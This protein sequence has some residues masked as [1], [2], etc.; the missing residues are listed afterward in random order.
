MSHLSANPND[1]EIRT[2]GSGQEYVETCKD[3]V[4]A[5]LVTFDDSPH[6]R[7]QEH[8]EAGGNRLHLGPLVPLGE[9]FAFKQSVD[10]LVGPYIRE[11]QPRLTK[12]PLSEKSV[13]D[14]FYEV[15][16][17]VRVVHV[18]ADDTDYR[19]EIYRHYTNPQ[20]P[21]VVSYFVEHRVPHPNMQA[22][23]EELDA[24]FLDNSLPWVAE[25]TCESALAT[26]LGFLAD[27]HPKKRKREV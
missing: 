9:W 7:I 15:K 6:I 21:Y 20:T 2:D 27:R 4:R 18:Q 10:K 26:A 1:S 25:R 17:L 11:S 8:H 12:D 13:R 24:Y 14:K 5:T 3:W 22:E 19:L 16:E 23:G